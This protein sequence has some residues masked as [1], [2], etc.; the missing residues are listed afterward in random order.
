MH[1]FVLNYSLVK[2]IH[3]IDFKKLWIVCDTDSC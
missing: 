3:W 2:C 1:K